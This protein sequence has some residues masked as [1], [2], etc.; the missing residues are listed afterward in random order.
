MIKNKLVVTEKGKLLCQA[1]ESQH[2]LT[3][4]E[5]TAKW[6]TYLKKIGKREGN[7][8]N[9]ITNIK[10]FIV[11][12]LEAVPNDIEKLNFSDYQEQKE[13]EAE[14]SITRSISRLF[15]NVSI[16]DNSLLRQSLNT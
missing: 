15:I 5:M 8:E 7:Q 11:H 4:A 13:K 16:S 12:L 14:K 9:F 10:K 3:S 2:L 6:E 1:V